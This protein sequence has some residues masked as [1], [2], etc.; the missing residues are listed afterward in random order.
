MLEQLQK[1]NIYV[2]EIPEE[3]KEKKE[4]KKYLMR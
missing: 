1:Y 2:F 3:K 4:Q